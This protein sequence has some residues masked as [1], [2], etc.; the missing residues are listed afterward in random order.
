MTAGT[1]KSRKAKVS[2]KARRLPRVLTE[3][4][5]RVSANS[6]SMQWDG[7]CRPS[8]PANHCSSVQ[9]RTNSTGVRYSAAA[10]DHLGHSLTVRQIE[11]VEMVCGGRCVPVENRAARVGGDQ[12]LDRSAPAQE[13]R[14]LAQLHAGDG[15]GDDG[16]IWIPGAGPVRQAAQRGDLAISAQVA[17][18]GVPAE[19]QSA[20]QGVA[21]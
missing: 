5:F 17:Q 20:A 19:R 21:V 11:K 8:S 10:V 7:G 18:A 16:L 15:D 6:A 14:H 1:V 4:C 9:V 12:P 3:A 13:A 2:R